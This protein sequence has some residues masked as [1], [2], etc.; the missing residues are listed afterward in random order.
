ME[1]RFCLNSRKVHNADLTVPGAA[2]AMPETVSASAAARRSGIV[3]HRVDPAAEAGWDDGLLAGHD[4]ATIFHSAAWA[5]VLKSAY[6][7]TPE[8]Q[9]IREGGKIRSLLPLV[10]AESWLKG[11]R[12][13]SLPFTDECG[14]LC[15]DEGDGQELIQAVLEQGRRRQ[16]KY[17]EFRGGRGW[18]GDA[19]ASASFF[20][21]EIPLAGGEEKLFEGLESSV[22]RAVR[23]AEKSGVKVEESTKLE[24][25][26]EFYHLLCLTR[27][28]H[29]MPPQPFGF[30]EKIHGHLLSRG[31][32][33]VILARHE[34]RALAGAVYFGFGGRAIYKY[35]ASDEREQ[36]F[37]ANNLVMWEAIKW[38]AKKGFKTLNLGRTSLSNEGLR[39]FKLGWGASEHKVEYFKY[40]LGRGRYV[41]DGDGEKG[42]H[43][44]VFR[45]LP[46]KVSQWIGAGL[47]RHWA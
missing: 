19:P 9:V 7:F 40:D 32:G 5:S 26:R 33:T 20:G 11:R 18:I 3:V 30:F 44:P 42:W 16:W 8:Y 4:G 34:G 43:N 37:R 31:L 6:G 35:G 47:Y 28:R 1:K 39:R 41:V 10:E 29:G 21:H 12:G 23:K 27:K 17:A 22:R 38:H 45:A 13:I 24:A 15:G 25:L 2:F 46:V 14:P 36:Q